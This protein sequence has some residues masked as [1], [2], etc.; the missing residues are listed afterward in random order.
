VVKEYGCFREASCCHHQ[1]RWISY[2]AHTHLPSWKKLQDPWTICHRIRGDSNLHNV[3]YTKMTVCLSRTDT[4][5]SRHSNGTAKRYILHGL[6]D[7]YS[8]LWQRYNKLQT[9]V[10]YWGRYWSLSQKIPPPHPS[11]LQCH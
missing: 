1:G 2:S 9:P 5:L 6:K 7:I 10:S 4:I 11:N 8:P 3:D